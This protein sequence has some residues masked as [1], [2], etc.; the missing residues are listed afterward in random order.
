M[1]GKMIDKSKDIDKIVFK[2]LAFIKLSIRPREF[3][4][5]SIVV[6]KFSSF[7]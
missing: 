7:A 6:A 1:V 2:L 4:I 5:F 3:L